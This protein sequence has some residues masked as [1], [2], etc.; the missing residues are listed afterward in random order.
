VSP[1][2]RKAPE[3]TGADANTRHHQPEAYTEPPMTRE[4]VYVKSLPLRAR[5]LGSVAWWLRDQPWCEEHL[6]RL[7]GAWECIYGRAT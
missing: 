7:A 2:K 6:A 4:G 5:H 1:G 3:G